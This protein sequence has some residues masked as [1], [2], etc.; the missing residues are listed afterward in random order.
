M[1]VRAGNICITG[2]RSHSAKCINYVRIKCTQRSLPHLIIHSPII[3]TDNRFPV[4][5]HH[6]CYMLY[7]KMLICS[8]N[9]HQRPTK[10]IA[11]V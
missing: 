9:T 11:F 10:R 6:I 1:I 5:L 8:S 3:Q 2:P 4:T 7:A